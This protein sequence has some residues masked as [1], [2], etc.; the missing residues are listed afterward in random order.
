MYM[1]LM[2][3]FETLKINIT[4]IKRNDQF[5]ICLPFSL[6]RSNIKEA[7]TEF[8]PDI[9]IYNAGTLYF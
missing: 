9:I 2:N 1:Y 6:F 7:L 3:Q 8:D 4:C 5:Y